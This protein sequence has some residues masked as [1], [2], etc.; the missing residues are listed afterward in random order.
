M[1]LSYNLAYQEI[2]LVHPTRR[3]IFAGK[4]YST[5]WNIWDLLIDLSRVDIKLWLWIKTKQW[6]FLMDQVWN[7][8]HATSND[9]L[10]RFYLLSLLLYFS[11]KVA[12]LTKI[13]PPHFLFS[14]FKRVPILSEVLRFAP[15]TGEKVSSVG[16][17]RSGTCVFQLVPNLET[18]SN[19]I[20]SHSV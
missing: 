13:S 14:N 12:A 4:P 18:L 11:K 20:S 7:P 2:I 17:F 6:I 16:Q 3:Q 15:S 5:F 10:W 1:T 19:W 9:Y 8:F